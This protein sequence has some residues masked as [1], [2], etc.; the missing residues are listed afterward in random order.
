M[1]LKGFAVAAA[2][3]GSAGGASTVDVGDTGVAEPDEVIDGLAEPGR[4]VSANDIDSAVPHRAGDDD[5]GHSGGEVGQVGRRCVGAEQ[6]QRLAAVLQQA[7]HG[8]ALVAAGSDG[9]EREFVVGV[10][11]GGVEPA[12]EVAVKGLL[13]GEHDADQPAAGTAQ[14]AGAA[15]GAVAQLLGDAPH[16]LPRRGTRPR[17]VAHHD[18][19]QRDG[20]AG[21]G[22]HVGQGGPTARRAAL[23]RHRHSLALRH[24]TF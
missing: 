14:Q 2:A 7:R 22:G 5:D 6:D 17:R 21:T 9:A 20:H 11:G 13:H 4:I 10:V 3:F 12:D 23:R 8:A 1:P 18:G 24:R 16:P 15:V 19:H